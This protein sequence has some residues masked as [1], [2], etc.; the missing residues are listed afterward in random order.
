MPYGVGQEVYAFVAPGGMR[1]KSTIR[2]LQRGLNVEGNGFKL[3]AMVAFRQE[4]NCVCVRRPQPVLPGMA[5]VVAQRGELQPQE[6]R[7]G[8]C[9]S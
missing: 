9:C 2:A 8:C 6:E 7:A 3:A 1:R 4:C 5:A